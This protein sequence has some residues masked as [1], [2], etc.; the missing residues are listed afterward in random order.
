MKPKL[1]K[2]ETDYETALARIDAL[3]DA[4][5]DTPAGEELEL[6]VTLVEMYEKKA[7]PID[8]PG[9]SGH[10]LPHEQQELKPKDLVPFISPA[11]R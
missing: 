7:H 11:L 2:N 6:L 9:P 1:I 4:E 8:L 5:P 3:M 10:P